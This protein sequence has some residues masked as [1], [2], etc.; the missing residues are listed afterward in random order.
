[1]TIQ[2]IVEMMQKSDTVLL[3]GEPIAFSFDEKGQEVYFLNIKNEK[4]MVG[5][6]AGTIW[7]IDWTEKLSIRVAI[8]HLAGS[9]GK[10]LKWKSYLTTTDGPP[11][12]MLASASS[13]Q[14]IKIWNMET[15]DQLLKIA[16]PKE[17]CLCVAFHPFKQMCVCSFSDGF[18]R[19]FDLLNAK[20][21]GRCMMNE[22]DKV[23]DLA[24][25]PNGTHILASSK[26]GMLDLISIEKYE[27]LSIKIMTILNT[28]NS[29]SSTKI[30]SIEPYAKLMLCSNNGKMSVLNRKKLTS[31]NYEAFDNDDMPKYILMDAFNLAEYESNGFKEKLT[32]DKSLNAYYQASAPGKVVPKSEP[33]EV[34]GDFSYIEPGIV[35]CCEKKGT[36]IYVRNYVLHQ[37][38]KRIPIESPI[39]TFDLSTS[40]N[41]VVISTENGKI[42]V[43]DCSDESLKEFVEYQA[44][45]YN[46]FQG[47]VFCSHNSIASIA[48]PEIVTY[49]I[50]N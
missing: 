20:N 35:I 30:S 36:N 46:A 19:F 27:P 13:D 6:T 1:M 15:Y 26:A 38:I 39:L 41:R 31:Q 5:T 44:D 4:G 33:K 28:R 2:K 9:E 3:D 14:S 11:R 50:T 21:M 42:K 40:K 32:G 45:S 25:F 29:I 17:E 47:A 16:I 10:Q 43:I 49:S 48:G 12:R 23:V 22:N 8:G 24:F 34:L 37:I 7:F 18:I